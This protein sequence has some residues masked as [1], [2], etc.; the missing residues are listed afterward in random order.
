M[1]I[2]V[3]SCCLYE[4]AF[5]EAVGK[6]FGEAI[7]EVIVADLKID[8]E[9]LLMPLICF[10]ETND[11]WPDSKEELAEF[12]SEMGFNV[13][14]LYWDSCEDMCFHTQDDGSLNIKFTR[15]ITGEDGAQHRFP[16]EYTLRKPEFNP[17]DP[18][19]VHILQKIEN[20]N[21]S[22]RR[23]DEEPRICLP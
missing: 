14:K 9:M 18:N 12:S 3:T 13:P 1:A 16:K 7:G 21:N 15:V 8:M 11:R 2:N 17:D 23:T 22:V 6:A 19:L 5:S 20:A 4:E 10:Q